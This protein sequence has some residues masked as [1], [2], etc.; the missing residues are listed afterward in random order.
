M[1]HQRREGV[2]ASLRGA[3]K[4][5]VTMPE[6]KKSPSSHTPMSEEEG[7]A[8]DAVRPASLPVSSEDDR[9]VFQG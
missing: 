5:R 3:P 4:V 2:R 9:V 6:L 7:V 8:V 1:S